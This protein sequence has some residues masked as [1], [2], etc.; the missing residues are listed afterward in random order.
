MKKTKKNQKQAYGYEPQGFG[1]E[2][3]WFGYEPHGFGYELIVVVAVPAAVSMF[4][5]S[6]FIK[7]K[8]P[9]TRRNP[10]AETPC[11]CDKTA[12]G[13]NPSISVQLQ[14]MDMPVCR[15]VLA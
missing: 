13:T 8:N 9:R 14:H 1:Y 7:A 5:E 12:L 3:Q 4:R 6:K 10:P 11:S 15:T 2:P